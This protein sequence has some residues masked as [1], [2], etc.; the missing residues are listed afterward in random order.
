MAEQ[1][2]PANAGP[3]FGAWCLADSELA[4]MLHRLIL[5]GDDVPARV[6]AYAERQWARP[7]VRE[8]AEHARPATVPA[9]YWA[10]SGTPQPESA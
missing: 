7:S 5:N 10:L 1:L 2:I 4:F 6:R 3:L 8:F 9:S